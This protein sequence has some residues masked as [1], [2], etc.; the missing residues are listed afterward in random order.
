VGA[1][2]ARGAVV[3]AWTVIDPADLAR[4][5]A[6]GVDAVVVDDPTIFASTLQT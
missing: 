1:A 2:H 4:V 3:V 6:A 5:D